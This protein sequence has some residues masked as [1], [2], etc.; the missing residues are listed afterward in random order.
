MC[1]PNCGDTEQQ[2]KVIYYGLPMRFCFSNTE[3]G[4]DCNSLYGF[5]SWIASY[6]PFNGWFMTYQGSYFK[7]LWHWLK[8]TGA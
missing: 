2:G 7:A 4:R 5:W 3:R 1:C 8:G 6:L